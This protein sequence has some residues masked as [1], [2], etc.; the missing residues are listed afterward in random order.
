MRSY[1]FINLSNGI[2]ALYRRDLS[3]ENV[4]FIRIQSTACEQKRW[5]QILNDLSPDF[6]LLAALGEN[7]I[8]YDYRAKKKCPRAIWQGMEWIK[9]VLHK[10]W[11]NKEYQPQ[12]RA[13]SMKQY[14]SEQYLR[15]GRKT[16]RMLDYYGK[17][18]A[19]KININSIVDS[20]NN[21]GAINKQLEWLLAA[22]RQQE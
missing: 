15:L 18:A 19:G 21:D 1:V 12:G 20:T 3:L 16:K 4:R 7:I 10:R 14:F 11:F 8:V 6:M 2:E 22:N 13:K 5:E 17:F 9:Y